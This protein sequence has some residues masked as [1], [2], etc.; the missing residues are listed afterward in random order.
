M[1][2]M[3]AKILW[4]VYANESVTQWVKVFLEPDFEYADDMLDTLLEYA[5]DTCSWHLE[6]VDL[7]GNWENKSL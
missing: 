5:S 1:T 7:F 3:K 6:E 2:K 4:R